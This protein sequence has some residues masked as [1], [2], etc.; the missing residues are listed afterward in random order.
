MGDGNRK[1][2][3][4]FLL[5]TALSC[6]FGLYLLIVWVM[7][8]DCSRARF[9]G[10]SPTLTTAL[11]CL[12]DDAAI[13]TVM[14]G[15]TAVAFFVFTVAMMVGQYQNIVERT[16]VPDRWHRRRMPHGT[17]MEELR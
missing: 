12:G 1:A 17:R 7:S 11:R 15:L 3:F 2:F 13:A 9:G 8:L 14:L 4:L 6:C 16:T 10:A 5:Y